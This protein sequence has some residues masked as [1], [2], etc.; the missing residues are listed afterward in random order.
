MMDEDDAVRKLSRL[1]LRK[2]KLMEYLA[3]KGKLRPPN[4]KP[5]LRD[6]STK[7]KSAEGRC[8]KT[9]NSD[10]GKENQG[11]GPPRLRLA[12]KERQ[13]LAGTTRAPFQTAHQFS[14]ANVNAT[15]ATEC[16]RLPAP[17][18]TCPVTTT[19]AKPQPHG[20]ASGLAAPITASKGRI[21]TGLVRTGSKTVVLSR[22]GSKAA[23]TGKT[24]TEP[25]SRPRTSPAAAAAR[26]A[27]IT[28]GRGVAASSKP[29][30][31]KAPSAR[32][33][34][35][36]HAPAPKAPNNPIQTTSKKR[37]PL[38]TTGTKSH[39]S[40]FQKMG[41]VQMGKGRPALRSTGSKPVT[42]T[43][44]VEHGQALAKTFKVSLN[45][46]Q[47]KATRGPARPSALIRQTQPA[48]PNPKGVASQWSRTGCRS[49]ASASRTVD[50]GEGQQA[51]AL[52]RA[53][54]QTL[55]EMRRK[56]SR[57]AVS[58]AEGESKGAACIATI[59]KSPTPVPSGRVAFTEL[60]HEELQRALGRISTAPSTV[61]R[62]TRHTSQ[63]LRPE[64]LK[65]PGIIGTAPPR[66]KEKLT[67]AQEERIQKL[68]EW[69]QAKG[70]SYKRPPMPARQCAKKTTIVP[71]HY[72]T[73]MEEEDE[74]QSLV[75]NID[76]S[77]TDCIK[78]LQEGCPSGQ[79][80]EVLSRVPMA[81]K[82][83]KYWICQA[84]LMESE[85]NLEVLPMFEEAVRVVLEPVDDLRAVVFEILKKK[86]E[87]SA[88]ES[89]GFP[90][91]SASEGKKDDDEDEDEAHQA[92]A[93]DP[94]TPRAT[95]AIIRGTKEGSSVVKYKITATPGGWRSQQ[96]EPMTLDGQEVRFFT[97][98]RR[99]VRIE[100]S[101]PRY[102]AALQ[103]H[104]PCV[105]S[106]REL[107]A[108][109]ENE[110]SAD[111]DRGS[112]LYIYRENEALRD[113]VQVQLF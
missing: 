39:C 5:Y 19:R 36:V 93:I 8:S 78:L 14:S 88:E 91:A 45:E 13:P 92:A 47:A 51:R 76:R 24:A 26:T 83:A 9:C 79:V 1:E 82:F 29:G 106:F 27:P 57:S 100:R 37:S 80:M 7:H 97:P 33:R 110:G 6:D 38:G 31:G 34:P 50:A 87:A 64:D 75:Y 101:A 66:D 89:E 42:N 72:W 44:R 102:P 69:R 52:Q 70:I 25:Q 71:N 59:P 109:E 22:N 30:P 103:E 41:A 53:V 46:P 113:Q 2:Q 10:E 111:E 65:T 11:T 3:A 85:G 18:S 43:T 35:S 58:G 16:S 95:S 74:A 56:G 12:E 62:T 55:T 96:Q 86:E 108:E 107:L 28:T 104:D 63:P 48:R 32:A 81:Q 54:R 77:L 99:S 84:R 73:A 68:Q 61:P 90:A 17:G 60:Q 98:V 67:A 112:P 40:A 94:V 49:M 4:S 21:L 15:R 105:A 23:T 20:A